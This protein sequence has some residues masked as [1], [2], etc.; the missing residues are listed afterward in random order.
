MRTE[1]AWLATLALLLAVSGCSTNTK[2]RAV[3]LSE[4]ASCSAPQFARSDSGTVVQIKFVERVSGERE[5]MTQDCTT[6]LTHTQKMLAGSGRK[7]GEGKVVGNAV[8]TAVLLPFTVIGDVFQMGSKKNRTRCKGWVLKE[9]ENFE[10]DVVRSARFAGDVTLVSV[11]NPEN[12]QTRKVE[13]AAEML[14][15]NVASAE[16]SFLMHIK[17]RYTTKENACD[18]D[19]QILLQGK[20]AEG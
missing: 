20:E 17:G 5:L 14:S 8:G 7:L 9:T 15:F 10:E 16:E 4:T 13:K 2:E 11:E 6:Y 18:V 19:Q 3:T 1:I 12:V